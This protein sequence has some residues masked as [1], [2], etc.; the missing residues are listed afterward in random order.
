MNRITTISYEQ[1]STEPSVSANI[2]HS[3][4]ADQSDTRYLSIDPVHRRDEISETSISLK[5]VTFG[6]EFI[7]TRYADL[8]T[9]YL[10]RTVAIQL[11]D[12]IGDVI[13]STGNIDT[14]VFEIQSILVKLCMW[15]DVIFLFCCQYEL[16]SAE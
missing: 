10:H 5:R 8:V 9:Y 16:A 4:I 1:N 15:I 3:C 2:S 12:G 11:R 7:N 14:D 13:L 6:R